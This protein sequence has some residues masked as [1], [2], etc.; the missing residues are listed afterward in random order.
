ML[1]SFQLLSFPLFQTQGISVQWGG[2]LKSPPIWVKYDTY[3][4]LFRNS[5][6]I[7]TVEK[8]EVLAWFRHQ[9]STWRNNCVPCFSQIL[10]CCNT[11][12]FLLLL[13]FITTFRYL[14][15]VHIDHIYLWHFD[16]LM[17]DA[18]VPLLKIL[19]LLDNHWPELEIRGGLLLEGKMDFPDSKK[20]EI[21]GKYVFVCR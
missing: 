14:I 6:D 7:R 18:I 8:T 2:N 9:I 13:T 1:G 10:Q 16:K 20:N 5:P 3:L 12:N 4:V 15:I 21:W 11:N 19:T 17:K